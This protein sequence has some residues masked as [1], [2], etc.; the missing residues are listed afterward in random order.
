MY[1]R[2]ALDANE[3]WGTSQGMTTWARGLPPSCLTRKSRRFS[4]HDIPFFKEE[5]SP[6]LPTD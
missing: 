1:A 2:R 6:N 3:P 5:A 4:G